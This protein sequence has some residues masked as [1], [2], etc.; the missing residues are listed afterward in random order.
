MKYFYKPNIHKSEFKKRRESLRLL[1]DKNNINDSNGAPT[2]P[3]LH[4]ELV[5]SRILR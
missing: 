4:T 1:M 2:V 3:L 5:S